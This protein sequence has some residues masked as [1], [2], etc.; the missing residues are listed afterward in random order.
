MVRRLTRPPRPPR[1]SPHAVEPVEAVGKPKPIRLRKQSN[2]IRLAP[3]AL[4]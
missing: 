2:T 1:T 4:S 3:A